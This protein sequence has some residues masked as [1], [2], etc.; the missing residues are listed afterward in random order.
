[1]YSINTAAPTENL[2]RQKYLYNI[3]KS[4]LKLSKFTKQWGNSIHSFKSPLPAELELGPGNKKMNKVQNKPQSP[5]S[6]CSDSRLLN[7]C[8]DIH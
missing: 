3:L 2:K 7:P 5:A 4:E 1:M 6:S 8:F